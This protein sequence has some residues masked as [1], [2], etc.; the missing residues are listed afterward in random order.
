MSQLED[1]ANRFL[2]ACDNQNSTEINQSY[3]NMQNIVQQGY[4]E[5]QN[6]VQDTNND[7]S[8]EQSP[9]K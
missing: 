7:S 9:T 1:E 8:S 2:N 3:N 4:S 5:P 6:S